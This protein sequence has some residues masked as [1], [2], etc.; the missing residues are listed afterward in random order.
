MNGGGSGRVVSREKGGNFDASSGSRVDVGGRNIREAATI[1]Q[2]RRSVQERLKQCPR[3]LLGVAIGDLS[4][5]HIRIAL[6][7][8][9]VGGSNSCR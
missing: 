8:S 6:S 1:D 9:S 5:K 4:N 3:V 2:T 7:V